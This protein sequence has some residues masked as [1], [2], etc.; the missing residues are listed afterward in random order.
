MSAPS[1]APFIKARPWLRRW[2][3]PI[4]EWYCHAAGYRQMGLKADDLIPE[5]ND[6]VQQ[7]LKRLTPQ[8]AYDRVF[9][10]RRAM[11]VHTPRPDTNRDDTKIPQLSMTHQLLPKE[12]WIKPE[13]DEPYL[14]VLIKEIESEM[15]EREDLEAMVISKRKRNAQEA[16]H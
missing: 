15:K 10:L 5:E 1:L 11:Q 14:D 9:R 12:E 8:Q 16:K 13:E 4:A 2:V 3:Q 7:A 6:V